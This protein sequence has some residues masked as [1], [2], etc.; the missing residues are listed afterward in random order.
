MTRISLRLPFDDNYP[1]T[2]GFGAVSNKEVIK[3]QFSQWGIISHNGL[4]YGL[5]SGAQVLAAAAGEVILSGDN[6]DFGISVVIKHSWGQSLYAHLKEAKVLVN[7]PVRSG[8]VIGLS[9][10]TG[11]AFGPHLHFAIMPNHP[12]MRNGYLGFIDPS[13][14]FEK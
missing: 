10:E 13:P 9:G 5:P 7:Q 3:N 6:A 8:Q 14:Y 12:D 11:V 4:D 1:L 2:F